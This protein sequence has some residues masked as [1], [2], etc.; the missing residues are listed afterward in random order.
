MLTDGHEVI[1]HF[2]RLCERAQQEHTT[3]IV[4]LFSPDFAVAKL[5]LKS[6]LSALPRYSSSPLWHANAPIGS[7]TTLHTSCHI[8]DPTFPMYFIPPFVP[9]IQANGL[10][11]AASTHTHSFIPSSLAPY[12]RIPVSQFDSWSRYDL[13][14][15]EYPAMGSTNQ[16]RCLVCHI[17][18]PEY[19]TFHVTGYVL[20]N[21]LTSFC[22]T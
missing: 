16:P 10:T 15:S 8:I 9:V 6:P 18:R 11:S 7:F 21:V 5:V 3:M 19:T 12:V 14:L 4:L 1:R 13:L 17:L 22:A 20:W 2:S